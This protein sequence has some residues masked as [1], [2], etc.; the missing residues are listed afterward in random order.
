MLEMACISLS[1]EAGMQRLGQAA[2]QHP[3]KNLI[4]NMCSR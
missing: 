3:G 1:M 2:H 4:G